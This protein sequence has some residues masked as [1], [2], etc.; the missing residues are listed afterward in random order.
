MNTL[1]SAT[2]Y[3][4]HPSILSW[5][6]TC[7][8][9]VLSYVFKNLYCKYREILKEMDF[10]KV[11]LLKTSNEIKMLSSKM[12]NNVDNLKTIIGYLERDL[13]K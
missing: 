12:D 1:I 6:L 11:E 2:D 3:M 4:G 5:T 7:I 13:K 9:A 8:S 10:L